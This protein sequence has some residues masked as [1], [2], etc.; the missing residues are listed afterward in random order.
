MNNEPDWDGAAIKELSPEWAGQIV[1]LP[2]CGSTNDEARKL[3]LKGAENLTVVLTEEQ[4]VGRGRRGQR[5]VCPAGE[6]VAFSMVL[7]PEVPSVLWSRFA[8]AAGL[9]VAEALEFFGVTTGVKWPNDVRV[10]G[11]KISGILVEADAEFLVIGVGINVNV[12]EFPSDLEFSATSLANELGR[13]E[14]REAV[15]V[16]CLQRL[17]V[18]LGQIKD[19]FNE[20]IQAWSER[21]VLTGKVV[22]MTVGGGQKTGMVEGIS[23][24]GELLLRGGKGV[25]RILQADLIREI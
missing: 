10:S 5:W 16:T 4:S 20:I 7:R 11:R 24:R 8:L 25:E 1:F 21:C 15:L 2:Q 13:Q 18:R 22:K 12:T 23:S 14:S 3:A 19:D 17:R 6:G 9:A